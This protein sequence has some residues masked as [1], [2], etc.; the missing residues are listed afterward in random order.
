MVTPP[1]DLKPKFNFFEQNL[2]V[3]PFNV[4]KLRVLGIAV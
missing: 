4:T 2:A 1:Q 3:T